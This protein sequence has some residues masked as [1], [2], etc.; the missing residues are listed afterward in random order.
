MDFN[1]MATFFALAALAANIVTIVLV[2]LGIMGRLQ[3]RNPFEALRGLTLW[4]AGTVALAATLGSLY[5]S[6]IAHLIPC[7]YCWFQRIAMYP[8]VVILLM[9]AYRRDSMARLYAA[10]IA[11]IGLGIAAYH[12][13]IQAFPDLDSGSCAATGPLCSGYYIKE[14]GFVTI[15]YMSLSAFALILTLLW[16]DRINAST[17]TPAMGTNLG[18]DTTT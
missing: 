7:R 16:A 4:F 9:A 1:T 13:F 12:R 5:L 3:N 2:V 8:L 6:E 11:T 14:F 15:P 10:T 18:A 17:N